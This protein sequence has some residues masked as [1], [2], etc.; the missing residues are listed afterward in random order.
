MALQSVGQQGE[1]LDEV[2]GEE[3]SE[4]PQSVRVSQLRLVLQRL[5]V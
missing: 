3:R 2:L 5:L 1:V 4:E